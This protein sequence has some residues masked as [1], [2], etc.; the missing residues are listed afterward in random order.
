M[1]ILYY[2]G[3]FP[4]F[5]GIESVTTVLSNYFVN[6]GDKIFVYSFHGEE[7]KGLKERLD[8][9]VNMVRAEGN[10]EDMSHQLHNILIKEEIDF[11]IFQDSYEPIENILFHAVKGTTCKVICC[12]H[13]TP[14][15]SLISYKYSNPRNLRERIKN[16]LFYYIIREKII[17]DT[18][19]RINNLYTK[20]DAYVL[21]SERFRTLWEKM[22]HISTPLKL[23][24]INNPL[25]IQPKP[26]SLVPKEE[27][28]CLFCARLTNQKGIDKL[29]KIW[30]VVA[31][32]YKDW[33]FIIVGDGECRPEIE[34]FSNSL[35]NVIYEGPQSD[36]GTYYKRASILCMTSI[37]EGWGLVLVEAMS[38]GCVP[39]LF[40]SYLSA[41]D[42]VNNDYNGILVS[43]Y[44]CNEYIDKL[45]ILFDNDDKR[46]MLSQ[47][48]YNSSLSFETDIIGAQWNRLFQKLLV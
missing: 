47:N 19:K 28:V 11:V 33:K 1:N 27:R 14:D 30:R 4:G 31:L 43:P 9:R 45:S 21:L 22:S 12:E 15:R 29:M 7:H 10:N 36:V 42:I 44:D 2:I 16:F 37:Y 26:A 39:I 13:N 3:N 5:G 24:A 46:Y 38:Y 48:A 41:K 32:K 6:Q 20:T 23:F 35:D 8:S 34:V 40:D 17:Y 25:T 18:R